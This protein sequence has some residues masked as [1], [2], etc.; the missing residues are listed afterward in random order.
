MSCLSRFLIFFSFCNS[1]KEE[2]K[3][4]IDLTTKKRNKVKRRKEECLKNMERMAPTKEDKDGKMSEIATQ[5]K[6]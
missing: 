2:I 5:S 4:K 1:G 3:M 6:K